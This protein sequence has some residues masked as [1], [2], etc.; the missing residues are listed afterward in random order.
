[1]TSWNSYLSQRQ[2]L[3]K[4]F[5]ILFMA[6]WGASGSPIKAFRPLFPTLPSDANRFLKAQSPLIPMFLHGLLLL[7]L[8]LVCGFCGFSLLQVPEIQ[9]ID[10]FID[11]P[12]QSLGDIKRLRN[13]RSERMASRKHEDF[14]EPSQW[15]CSETS[16]PASG[17]RSPNRVVLQFSFSFLN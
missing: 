12:V 13:K 3:Q 2:P 6:S 16:P 14:F 1:M 5:C 7:R 8:T 4:D 11:V 9:F 15:V 17:L 10:K